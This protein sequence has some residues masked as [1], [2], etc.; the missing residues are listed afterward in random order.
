MD[1]AVPR[2]LARWPSVPDVYGWLALDRRGEWRLR[3]DG[4]PVR[5]ERI[6]NRALR[7]FISRNYAADARGRWYFQN[8]P[9]R[10]FVSL[11]YAPLVV[12]LEGGRLFD[13]CGCPFGAPVGMWLDEE[14]SLLLLGPSGLGLLDDRDLAAFSALQG[15]GL[16]ELAV[17]FRSDAPQRFGYVPDPRPEA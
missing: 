11:A 3:G 14:G 17:V 5:F 2:A 4:A 12:R 10:V 8:G 13:H 16:A 9:Q 7:D 15:E 1:A 6:G